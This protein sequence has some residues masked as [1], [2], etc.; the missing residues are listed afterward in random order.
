MGMGMGT[1]LGL[2]R[3]KIGKRVREGEVPR[4][5]RRGKDFSHFP[6]IIFIHFPLNYPNFSFTN[7]K[8]LFRGA[9]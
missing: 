9:L 6:P 5:E 8:N 4:V 1:Q 2:I 3:E 7:K